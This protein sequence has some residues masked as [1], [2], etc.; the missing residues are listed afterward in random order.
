MTNQPNNEILIY[1]RDVEDG[2]L[3]FVDRAATG[4]SGSQT[5][6]PGN[7]RPPVND[8]FAA[9]GAIVVA[10]DGTQRCLLAVNAGSD[11]VSSF[12]IKSA[13]EIKLMDT[14]E[15]GKFPVSIAEREGLVYVL[16]AAGKGSIVG[17]DL[18]M[19]NCKLRPGLSTVL[20]QDE[21]IEF[22]PIKTSSPAQIGFTPSGKV[23]VTIKQNGGGDP[24]P[25]NRIGTLNRYDPDLTN[26]IQTSVRTDDDINAVPFS[27]TFDEDGNLLLLDLFGNGGT[28]DNG[29][30]V[31]VYRDIDG[32][33][34]SV[35]SAAAQSTGTCWI[36]YNPATSCAYGTNNGGSSIS[37]FYLGDDAEIELVSNE[38]AL[39]NAPIDMAMSRN[40]RYLYAMST[41]HTDGTGQPLIYAYEM[42]CGCGLKEVQAI[43][44]GLDDEETRASDNPGGVVNGVVGLAIY[45]P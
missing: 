20:Q 13:S 15:V 9:T 41:G 36:A 12:R 23:L 29:G 5:V 4:G 1:S 24:D 44:D 31:S 10:G 33:P 28:F 8:P 38:T 14:R 39:L 35:S 7:R 3:S 25:A 42:V 26:L 16:G 34:T 2:T 21:A 43:S 30:L 40:L 22:P 37:S 27:F 19:Y 32:F 6:L 45:D 11:T 18:T 17:F